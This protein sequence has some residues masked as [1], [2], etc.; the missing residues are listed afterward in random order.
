[1]FHDRCAQSRQD[2]YT[3]RAPQKD[4]GSVTVCLGMGVVLS[5]T[6][7]RSDATGRYWTDTINGSLL[8]ETL[9]NYTTNTITLSFETQAK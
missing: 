2:I 1:M 3:Y 4:I 6:L 8:E 7:Y 5:F 9:T